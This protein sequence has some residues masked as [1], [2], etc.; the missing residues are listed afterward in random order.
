MSPPGHIQPHNYQAEMVSFTK[1]W[2]IPY[3]WAGDCKQLIVEIQSS[4][5]EQACSNCIKS[6]NKPHAIVT[7]AGISIR[8]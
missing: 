8:L 3:P 4:D 5:S 6:R 7:I 2:L 1:K